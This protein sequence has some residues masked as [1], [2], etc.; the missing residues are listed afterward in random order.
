MAFRDGDSEIYVMNGDGSEQR[1]L[2]HNDA[3][4]Y[5]P[6]WSPDGTHLVFSS[7]RDGNEEI[8]VMDVQAALQ[9]TGDDG[10][11]RLTDNQSSDTA[12][13]WSPDGAHI[14][15]ASKRDGNYEIYV[16]DADGDNAQRLTTEPA[17]DSCP[18]WSPDGT[19]IAFSSRRGGNYEIYIMD[20]DGGDVTPLPIGAGDGWCPRWSPDG[21]QIAFYSYRPERYRDGVPN[22]VYV[23]DV[24]GGN[25]RALTAPGEASN[26][27]PAWRPLAD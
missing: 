3:D 19:R 1:Q 23:V 12:P 24:D 17:L 4:D 16:M 20:A 13:V 25:L 2:T 10:Q 18:A 8:Y 21:A 15:F 22:A 5:W 9:G 6:A 7:M 27:H 26:W 14:V 11:Q